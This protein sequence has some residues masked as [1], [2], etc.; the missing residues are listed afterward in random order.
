VFACTWKLTISKGK[1]CFLQLTSKGF[2]LFQA[3][4]Q[5]LNLVENDYFGLKF[6]GIHGTVV[7]PLNFQWISEYFNINIFVS[8]AIGL[9]INIMYK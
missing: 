8:N 2:I 5:H 9:L 1:C 3:V 6:Y 7:N 4:C